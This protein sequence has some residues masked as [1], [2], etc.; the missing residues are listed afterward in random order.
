MPQAVPP[1]AGS[2]DPAF[3]RVREAFA[4]NFAEHDEVGAAVCVRV[5]ERCVLDLWGGHADRA[6]T[7]PWQRDTL[8]NAYS[9]GK[10]VLAILFLACVE[11]GEIELDAPVARYWPEFAAGGKG[12]IPV[13][14]LL[15]HQAGLPSVR[16]R[17]PEGTMFDWDAMCSALAGQEPWWEPG[18]DHG[19]HVNSYGF[20]VGELIHRVTGRAVGDALQQRLARPAGGEFWYGL[21]EALL[22]RAAEVLAPGVAPKTEAEWARAFPPSG[23]AEHDR[24]IWHC[25]FNPSGLSGTGN[26]NTPEWRRAAIPSTN[27]HGTARGVAALYAAFL[28]GAVPGAPLASAALREEATRIHSDGVDRV[29]G[30]PSRF[31]LGFQLGQPTRAVGTGER[32]FG[33]F[34]YGGSLGFADPDS[35]VAFAYLMNRPGERWQT[36]RAQALLEALADC[37]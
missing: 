13:R 30:R 11:R 24:M 9:V 36:P 29:L 12:G 26:V 31:G 4:A 14:T 21:P 10:G 33:H 17:L 37:L 5:G 16:A 8:V 34:G 27:G 7:R 2:C 3:A 32:A 6:R 22:G 25:Y 1:I 15:C 35:G 19:Y 23:D 18:S 20:L 28:R